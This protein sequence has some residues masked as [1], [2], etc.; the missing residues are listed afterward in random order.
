MPSGSLCVAGKVLRH[1]L[2]HVRR[3]HA[4]ALPDDEMRGV[5][6]V[7]DVAVVDLARVFLADALEVALG[8]RAL[9]AARRRRDISPRTPWRPS[10]RPAGRPRCTRDLA[11]LLRR[12][13]QLRRDLARLGRA[14]C[15]RRRDEAAGRQRRGEAASTCRRVS[16]LVMR[17]IPPANARQRSAGRC[18]QTRCARRDVLLRR[19]PSRAAR[20]CRRARP[21]SRAPR[22]ERPAG[23]TV[24]VQRFA[25]AEA[26]VADS[27]ISCWRTDTATVSPA[28]SGRPACSAAAAADR[29]VARI[30]RLARAGCCCRR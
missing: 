6:A 10:R 21:Y 4:L 18:S 2:G 1:V 8:A 25:G 15:A 5:G 11:F 27:S 3:Q 7:H 28:V 9:D 22:R 23:V 24:G 16:F 26:A 17:F 20:S 13:D 29:D 19:A 14:R 30:E 12:L